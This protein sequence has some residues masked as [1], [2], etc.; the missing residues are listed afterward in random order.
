[1]DRWS[2]PIRPGDI[3]PAVVTAVPS[4]R[5]AAVKVRIAGSDVDLLPKGFAWARGIPG[6]LFK[7]KDVPAAKL[8]KV[9]DLI[10]VEVRTVD[11]GKLRD[12]V[13]EQSPTLEGAIVAIENRTGQI[14]AMVGGFSFAR[15]KF[16]RATQARRQ[17]GSLFKP[18]VFTAAID[19]GF[20]PVSTF[21]DEEIS[22]VAGPDQP[23]YEPKNYDKLYKGLVTLR[24]AL[25][26]S[27][28]IPG[29]QGDGRDRSDGSRELRSAIRAAR[30]RRQGLPALLVSG[31][32]RGRGAA[33][34]H[35]ECVLRPFPIRASG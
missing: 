30:R 9:G 25:E 6:A 19:H 16:N 23:P 15:S 35:D 24:E 32:G 33:A 26:D 11:K 31:T 4:T 17:V 12:L 1:M 10:D 28:N 13:L 21:L 7:A 2:R 34:R 8:F 14:R 18:F 27:R 5:T 22:Y 20:T 29:C 3:V